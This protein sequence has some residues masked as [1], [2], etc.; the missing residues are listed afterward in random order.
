[1]KLKE[2]I[3]LAESLVET[4]VLVKTMNSVT[5]GLNIMGYS[6]AE[7]F[8]RSAS[9]TPIPFYAPSDEQGKGVVDFCGQL[10]AMIAHKAAAEELLISFPHHLMYGNDIDDTTSPIEAGLGWITKFTKEFINSKDLQKQKEQGVS[11]KLVGFELLER[12]VPRN[13]YP[14]LNKEGG[15]IGR[16]TSGTMAPF[17]GKPIV[18]LLVIS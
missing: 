18:M 2:M 9:L 13:G 12:G 15:V 14:I 3:A 1:M 8:K 7:V 4:G 16:V 6:N 5:M 11:K 17:L 10:N